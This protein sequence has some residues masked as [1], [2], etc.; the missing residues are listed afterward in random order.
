MITLHDMA[1][2]PTAVE[3]KRPNPTAVPAP[4][5]QPAMC[6]ACPQGQSG[7]QAHSKGD[8]VTWAAQ[9]HGTIA[10]PQ[11]QLCAVGGLQLRVSYL[12]QLA[13]GL[14]PVQNLLCMI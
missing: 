3:S 7:C 13:A 1:T 14:L 8:A 4:A 11:S 2:K 12:H 10:F 6:P 9:P 5:Q